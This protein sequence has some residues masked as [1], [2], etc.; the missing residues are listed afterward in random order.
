M[1][2]E[3]TFEGQPHPVYTCP[4]ASSRC[5]PSHQLNSL[6]AYQLLFSLHD[7][8]LFFRQIVVL[9]NQ[10]VD[11]CI[12]GTRLACFQVYSFTGRSCCG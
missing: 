8:D 1:N 2:P 6:L 11:G 3:R 5:L 12:R 7:V 10:L 4:R 9:V